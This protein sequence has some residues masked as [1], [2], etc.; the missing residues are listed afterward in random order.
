MAAWVYPHN[1]T[2]SVAVMSE[3]YTGAVNN[4]YNGYWIELRGAVAGDFVRAAKKGTAAVTAAY[5]STAYVA[6]AWQHV[7]GIFAA[8]NDTR[9][10][11]NGGGK[12]TSA[13]TDTPATPTNTEIGRIYYQGADKVP[14]GD[15]YLDGF[16]AGVAIW[17]ATLTDEQVTVLALG[18]SPLCVEPANLVAYWPLIGKFATEIDICNSYGMAVTGAVVTPHPRILYPKRPLLTPYV[19]AAGGGAAPGACREYYEKLMAGAA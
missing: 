19:A 12:G 15:S 7:C 3:C 2:A 18:V 10:F 6:N 13:G 1:V 16:I 5:T 9:V 14:F 11:L 17:N 4:S 8:A